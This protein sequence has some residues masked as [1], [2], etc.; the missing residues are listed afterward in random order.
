MPGRIPKPRPDPHKIAS[1]PVV[2]GFGPVQ[3]PGE[4]GDVIFLWEQ[5][6][7]RSNRVAPT[8]NYPL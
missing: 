1:R 4:R 5:E 8:S 3:V 7:A 2:I 6:V